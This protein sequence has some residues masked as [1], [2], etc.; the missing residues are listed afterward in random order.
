M[1]KI[2]FAAVVLLMT[3]LML[4]CVN[5]SG[6]DVSPSDTES[7]AADVSENS[8]DTDTASKAEEVSEAS[9]TS[10]PE[11]EEVS[12]VPEASEEENLPSIFKTEG[13]TADK[14]LVS[15][16]YE[17]IHSLIENKNYEKAYEL[18][19][20][21]KY[22]VYGEMLLKRFAELYKK[23]EN[24]YVWFYSGVCWDITNT[25]ID[26]NGKPIQTKYSTD[27]SSNAAG[28]V[29]EYVYNEKGLL[30]E[31]RNDQF[32]YDEQN[33][34]TEIRSN[35][36][37]RVYLYWYNTGLLAKKVVYYSYN[38]EDDIPDNVEEYFYRPDGRISRM[39]TYGQSGNMSAVT[40]WTHNTMGKISTEK[41]TYRNGETKVTY[42]KYDQDENLIEI[43]TTD[44]DGHTVIEEY[45]Y[46]LGKLSVHRKYD[47]DSYYTYFRYQYIY[48]ENGN[49]KNMTWMNREH[50]AIDY[51]VSIYETDKD[52][53]IIRT[54]TY[55][56]NEHSEYDHNI[57]TAGY[58]SEGHLVWK[59]S[60][61]S[62]T[63][64]AWSKRTYS[65][66][67]VYYNEYEE[68]MLLAPAL[69]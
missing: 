26:E 16:E 30:V 42:Y 7:V 4:A 28:T 61:N 3:L 50:L 53:N 49:L 6:K 39:N 21:K 13:E 64:E 1:K 41:V 44:S 10:V 62:E 59:N 20:Q 60:G 56:Y 19:K 5:E 14:L 47:P 54:E 33:R 46:R 18:L 22:D 65:G 67:V 34:L 8:A 51:G 57:V 29:Y 43:K 63:D 9:E 2:L 48:D 12:E 24:N 11:T 68:F 35:A 38:G 23:I 55:G 15:E 45:T 36:G 27:P 66:Y 40:Q 37:R 58:D 32:F 52:G 69:Q 25:T 31:Y 17:Y